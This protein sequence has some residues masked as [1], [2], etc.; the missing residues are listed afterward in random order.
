MRMDWKT[1]QFGLSLLS[2]FF[3]KSPPPSTCT[4]A[5][6]PAPSGPALLLFLLKVLKTLGM[7]SAGVA[8][9]SPSSSRMSDMARDPDS[10]DRIDADESSVGRRDRLK[11]AAPPM[12]RAA[13]LLPLLIMET[14]E[15][16]KLFEN[17]ELLKSVREERELSPMV[18]TDG[19]EASPLRTVERRLVWPSSPSFPLSVEE[20]MS[21]KFETSALSNREVD[22]KLT[23]IHPTSDAS[24]EVDSWCPPMRRA[25]RGLRLPRDSRCDSDPDP[26][27]ELEL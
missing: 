11:T 2:V 5:D 24:D 6:W 15:L 12:A 27:D 18:L 3:V 9:E 14:S 4:T 7:T 17:P 13:R 25:R 16:L 23:S 22:E 26:T 20:S 19:I 21:S 8:Q 10:L 1:P